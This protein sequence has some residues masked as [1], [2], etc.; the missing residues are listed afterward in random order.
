MIALATALLI[1]LFVLGIVQVWHI[2]A[3][4]FIRSLGDAFHRPAMI[5]STPLMVPDEH[6]TRIQGLNQMIQGGLNIIGAPLGAILIETLSVEAVMAV[7]IITAAFAIVPLLMVTVPEP[8]RLDETEGG[9]AGF[10]ADLRGGWRYV[11]NWPGMIAIAIIAMVINMVL[12]P[13]SSLMPLLITETF[14]QGALELGWIDAGYGIGVIVG[15]VL[16]TAWGGFKRRIFTSALGL[17]GIGVGWVIIGFLP[18][19]GFVIA[20]ACMVVVG[21]AIPL[22]NGP[23]AAIMQSTVRPDML[24]RVMSLLGSMAQ[25]MSILGLVLAGPVADA[26]GVQSWFIVGGA[27]TLLMAVA[28]V[29]LRPVREI[30]TNANQGAAVPVAEDTP[31]VAPVTL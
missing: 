19:S 8:E 27:I 7:D 17:V 9:F 25:A 31:E 11:M 26:L 4:M 16:L 13:A 20:L 3:L 30:E 21:I 28:A 12:T 1:A 22:T 5:A 10:V 2:Y 24:G 15:S 23:I 29:G 14:K 6:L 18:P